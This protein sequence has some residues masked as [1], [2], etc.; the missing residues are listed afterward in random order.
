MMT[1]G[2]QGYGDSESLQA[3]VMRFMAIIAF[4][5]IAILALVKNTEAPTEEQASLEAPDTAPHAPVLPEQAATPI[6]EPQEPVQQT[7][8]EAPVEPVP[9]PVAEVAPLPMPKPVLEATPAVAAATPTTTIERPVVEPTPAPEPRQPAL[10]PSSP[11]ASTVDATPAEPPAAES[12][13]SEEEGLVLRFA[14]DGDFMRLIARGDITV[15]AF[16]ERDVL[17]L[18]ESYRFFET[19]SPGQVYELLLPSI[20]GLVVD[21]L[22]QER[23]NINGYR[24][25]IALPRH[26]SNQ[27]ER[28]L[29]R[30]SRGELVIDRFGD[31]RHVAAS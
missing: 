14:S 29:N 15:Y 5:L 2:H 26:I 16:Q 27:I 9:A 3:D 6:E 19:S 17:S 25:G 11:T 20:P 13:E 21:A 31:V 8:T 28:H 18:N 30:V 7:P 1:P 4:C 24:W 12:S 23:S 22:R 10:A